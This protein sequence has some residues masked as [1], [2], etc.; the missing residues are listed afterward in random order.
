MGGQG[1]SP[2]TK[3]LS[4]QHSSRAWPETELRT[5][6]CP[7]KEVPGKR[8]W[9]AKKQAPE[10][11]WCGLV[12]MERRGPPVPGAVRTPMWAN[13][14]RV[15]YLC[16]GAAPQ[17]CGRHTFPMGPRA[18]SRKWASSPILPTPGWAGG[19]GWPHCLPRILWSPHP[20]APTLCSPPCSEHHCSSECRTEVMWLTSGEDTTTAKLPWCFPLCRSGKP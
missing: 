15:Q 4:E 18:A 7:I 6:H 2:W 5:T 3:E 8:L 14:P 17:H 9:T 16:A 11:S 12:S 1:G 13:G 19:E 20:L 10:R